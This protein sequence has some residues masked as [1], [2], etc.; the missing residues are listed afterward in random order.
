LSKATT[1]A[2]TGVDALV[3]LTGFSIWF[4][5]VTKDDLFAARSG[6]LRP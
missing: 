2:T 3:P 5:T 1:L 4:H 6:Y